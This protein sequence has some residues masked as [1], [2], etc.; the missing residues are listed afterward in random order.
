M[1][2]LTII[3]ITVIIAI[4]KHSLK[5][6]KN[7]ENKGLL[8]KHLVRIVEHHQRVSTVSKSFV[9]LRM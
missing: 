3:F 9:P 6:I 1:K 4:R 5:R 2:L 7:N 8:Q